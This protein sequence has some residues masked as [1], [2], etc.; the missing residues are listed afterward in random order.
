[1]I[2]GLVLTEFPPCLLFSP[3]AQSD[4]GGMKTLQRRWTTFLKTE[5]VC[6]DK[7]RGQRYNILTD[8]FTMQHTEGDP[9][10]THFYGLFTSQWYEEEP[11]PVLGFAVFWEQNII[12]ML[13]QNCNQ[14]TCRIRPSNQ[15]C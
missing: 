12:Q 5:L 8:V 6:E 15:K 9:A 13:P 14:F 3:S 7:P 10:S 11:E 4:V 2:D 1:M